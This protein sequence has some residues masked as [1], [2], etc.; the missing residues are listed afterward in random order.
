MLL[1]LERMLDFPTSPVKVAED[2][3]DGII[4]MSSSDDEPREYV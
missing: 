2:E 4:F 1:R 3:S